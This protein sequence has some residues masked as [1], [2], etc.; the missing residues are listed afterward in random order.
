MVTEKIEPPDWKRG[1][2][3][4]LRRFEEDF[5]AWREREQAQHRE[6]CA[7]AA[8][9]RRAVSA[10]EEESKAVLKKYFPDQST[11]AALDSVLQIG[12]KQRQSLQQLLEL[13]RDNATHFGDASAVLK[14]LPE[15]G[16]RRMSGADVIERLPVLLDLASRTLVKIRKDEPDL[17]RRQDREDRA[18][19][20]AR[21][22]GRDGKKDEASEDGSE[23]ASQSPDR[24]QPRAA[25]GRGRDGEG[26]S[27]AAAALRDRSRSREGRREP[28][29]RREDRREPSARRDDRLRREDDRGSR[30]D[31]RDGSRR[32]ARDGRGRRDGHAR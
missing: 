13:V 24:G 25:K 7:T 4:P 10:A 3:Q 21:G 29:D 28:R 16:A 8:L 2:D 20:A 30:R 12:R 23:Y 27:S 1:L 19:P 15:D 5:Q 32:D 18:R 31:A 6:R 11:D 14:E 17:P 22:A 9:D 26:R